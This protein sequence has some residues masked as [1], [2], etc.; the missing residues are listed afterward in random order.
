RRTGHSANGS[1]HGFVGGGVAAAGSGC[2]ASTAAA[3]SFLGLAGAARTRVSRVLFGITRRDGGTSGKEGMAATATAIG[4]T[5]NAVR[6]G[7]A[8]AIWCACP[9][10]TGG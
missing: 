6:G 2:S 4:S 9:T 8:G 3:R 5:R 10:A 1:T 7:G